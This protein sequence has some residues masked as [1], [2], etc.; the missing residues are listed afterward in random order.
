MFHRALKWASGFDYRT[1]LSSWFSSV[2]VTVVLL[3]W[4]AQ[5]DDIPL[6]LV[7]GAH[8]LNVTFEPG[9]LRP[10]SPDLIPKLPQ[11]I[12]NDATALASQWPQALPGFYQTWPAT[13]PKPCLASTRLGQLLKKTFPAWSL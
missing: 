7:L 1:M 13:G 5:C 10:V 4:L 8:G 2:V 12:V 11:K 3:P 9:D 6:N